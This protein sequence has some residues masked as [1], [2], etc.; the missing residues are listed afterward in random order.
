MELIVDILF[1]FIQLTLACLVLAHLTKAKNT[2]SSGLIKRGIQLLYLII[3]MEI[4][5][6]TVEHV[7]LGESFG[8]E[9]DITLEVLLMALAATATYYCTKVRRVKTTEPLGTA[10]ICTVWLVTAYTLEFSLG[11]LLDVFL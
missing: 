2:L 8:D 10:I 4:A 11:L 3:I 9:D 5:E 6:N 1:D 7:V